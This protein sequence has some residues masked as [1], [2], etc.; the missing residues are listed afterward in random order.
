MAECMWRQGNE[1]L[2]NVRLSERDVQN[3]GGREGVKLGE[4]GIE[5][6]WSWCKCEVE[7]MCIKLSHCEV[8]CEV[9]WIYGGEDL[10]D[11]RLRKIMKIICW[12]NQ[13]FEPLPFGCHQAA[14]VQCGN[15][16]PVLLGRACPELQA[17]L[18]SSQR[19]PLVTRHHGHHVAPHRVKPHASPK[20]LLEYGEW[21][22]YDLMVSV[23]VSVSNSL[24]SLMMVD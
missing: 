24:F 9:E 16:F 12:G 18:P 19:S 1:S 3:I 7:K 13:R 21:L 5:K 15:T 20:T 11:L 22:E 10:I 14:V 8:R 17:T 23:S 4:C 6:M 2:G